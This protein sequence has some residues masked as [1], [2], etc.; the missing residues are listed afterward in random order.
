MIVKN[1]ASFPVELP[2]LSD[3]VGPVLIQPGASAE[4]HADYMK[5]EVIASWCKPE[6]NLLEPVA[7]E[8]KPAP[9]SKKKEDKE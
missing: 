8:P 7:V 5:N 3:S 4:M 2:R 6:S 9:V 1:I